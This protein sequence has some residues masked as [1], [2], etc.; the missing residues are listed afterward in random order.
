MK[1]NEGNIKYTCVLYNMKTRQTRENANAQI[2]EIR[3]PHKHTFLA[4]W[5]TEKRKKHTT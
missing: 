3:E 4:A 5:M 2:I 1:W